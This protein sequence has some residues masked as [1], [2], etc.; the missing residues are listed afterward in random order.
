MAE[1]RGQSW[2]K[3]AARM[4]LQRDLERGIVSLNTRIMRPKVVYDMRP[5][6]QVID[7]TKFVERLRAMRKQLAASKGRAL[8]D[9][10]AFAHDR[11]MY[12]EPTHNHKG[13][14]RWEGSIAQAL[15]KDEIYMVL[16]L[17]VKPQQLYLSRS[18]Y[19]QYGLKA[20]RD[21]IY[22]MDRTRKFLADYGGRKG[23]K[24]NGQAR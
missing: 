20:F 22:Q 1:N 19:Q 7:Y 4:L 6:Y 17:G 12:P 11:A 23:R 5:E 9:S 16:E 10:D 13:E 21:K 8:S 2:S 15:L 3:S 18:E 24:K 14:P